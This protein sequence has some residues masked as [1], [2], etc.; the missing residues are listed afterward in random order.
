MRKTSVVSASA[1]APGCGSRRSAQ[2][3]PH[4]GSASSTRW[5]P[6]AG[7]TRFSP[8][9]SSLIRQGRRTLARATPGCHRPRHASLAPSWWPPVRAATREAATLTPSLPRP[10]RAPHHLARVVGGE[11]HAAR[12]PEEQVVVEAR[13]SH[14][15]RV[16]DG[17]HLREVV[18][19]DPGTAQPVYCNNSPQQLG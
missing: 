17:R 12:P 18:Q 16:H 14:G 7:E 2:W 1:G 15:R 5:R 3:R 4:H 19:Q 11:V 9:H 13:P 6:A 10:R 8:S